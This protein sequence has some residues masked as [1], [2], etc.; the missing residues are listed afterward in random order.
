MTPEQQERRAAIFDPE[1]HRD[2]VLMVL[3]QGGV[4]PE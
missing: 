3:H 2:D 1:G 4:E